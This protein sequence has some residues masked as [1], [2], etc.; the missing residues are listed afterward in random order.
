MVEDEV[1]GLRFTALRV[2]L[3]RMSLEF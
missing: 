3:G 2:L 1:C